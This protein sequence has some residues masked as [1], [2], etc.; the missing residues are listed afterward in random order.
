MPIKQVQLLRDL[1]SIFNLNQDDENDY[2]LKDFDFSYLDSINS[3][4]SS[5]H[6]G[7]DP[8]ILLRNAFEGPRNTGDTV[9]INY[10]DEWYVPS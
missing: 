1:Q 5:S 8:Q 9:Q 3:P 10:V 7:V 2:T 4:N 6:V